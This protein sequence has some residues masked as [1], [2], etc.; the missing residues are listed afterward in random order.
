MRILFTIVIAGLVAGIVIQT[1]RYSRLSADNRELERQVVQL[2]TG[3]NVA[4]KAD[5]PAPVDSPSEQEQTELLRLRNQAALLRSASNELREV[6]KQIDPLQAENRELKA[7][8]SSSVAGSADAS[9]TGA[10]PR[11]SWQ[12]SGYTTPEACLESTLYAISKADYNA[13]MGSLTPEEAQRLQKQMGDGSPEQ[14]AEKIRRDVAKAT[15]YQ[16]LETR[17]LSP[18]EAMLVIY[19]AGE[20][21]AQRVL[22]QKIGQEWRFAGSA[23]RRGQ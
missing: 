3:L 23:D 13:I 12:F 20:E 21:K 10:R 16:V 14:I 1:K 15:S 11:E 22:M 4:T 2:Q 5:G 7:T 19:A 17:E 8:G 9:S 18:N 6:R